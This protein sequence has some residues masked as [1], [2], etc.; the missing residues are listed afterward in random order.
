MH[1][2]VTKTKIFENQ[3]CAHYSL[4][5]LVDWQIV[6]CP[7]MCPER[8]HNRTKLKVFFHSNIKYK[9]I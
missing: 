5:N 8:T 1:G 3:I 2:H 7:E 6:Y 4:L 9:K